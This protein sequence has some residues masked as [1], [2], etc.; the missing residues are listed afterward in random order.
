AKLSS[1]DKKV[2]SLTGDGSYMFS[3]PS[4]VHWISRKYDLPFLT[5]IYNNRGWKSPKLSTL[6]VY[7][8]GVAKETEQYWID[9]TPNANLAGIAEA[10]SGAFAQTIKDSKE[11]IDSL[12]KAMVLIVNEQLDM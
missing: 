5:I 11:L 2:I 10:A 8:K 9:F 12:Y 1:K 6:G 7:P 4:A 3:I